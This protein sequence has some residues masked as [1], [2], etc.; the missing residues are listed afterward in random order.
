M[1]QSLLSITTDGWKSSR[2]RDQSVSRCLIR[3]SFSLALRDI[4]FQKN[5]NKLL[6][7]SFALSGKNFTASRDFE[8]SRQQGNPHITIALVVRIS[9]PCAGLVRKRRSASAE[10]L[11]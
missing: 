2:Q 6:K 4:L 9:I 7:K 3:P 1:P 5:L 10:G 11:T 8:E